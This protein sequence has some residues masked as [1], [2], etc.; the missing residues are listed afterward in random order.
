MPKISSLDP[1]NGPID[2]TDQLVVVDSSGA[3]TNRITRTAFLGPNIAS[4]DNKVL[5]TGDFVGTSDTQALI[6]KTLDYEANTFLNWPASSAGG[7]GLF[8]ESVDNLVGETPLNSTTV[9]CGGRSGGV[10]YWDTL[11]AKAD[12]DGATVIS[13][14]VPLG[15]ATA[16]N[17]LDGV[18]ETDAAGDGVWVRM[19]P[20]G[21][22][23]S[24]WFRTTADPT[25]DD[26]PQLQR[27][28]NAGAGQSIFIEGVYHRHVN[29]LDVVGN[30]TRIVLLPGCTLD[31][32]LT[33]V[34]GA[35]N[36]TT[37]SFMFN[38]LT[39]C[40]LIGYG[41]TIKATRIAPSYVNT[42]YVQGC[43]D[44]TIEGVT[45][46]GSGKDGIYLGFGNEGWPTNHHTVIRNCRIN[47]CQRQGISLIA[48]RDTLI[49]GCIIHDISGVSPSAAIDIEGNA[50]DIVYNTT[51]TNCHVYNCLDQGAFLVT[52][53]WNTIISN[54][55][56]YKC[57]GGLNIDSG[58][59]VTTHH[60]ITAVDD[61]NDTFTVAD[62]AAI[63]LI[64]HKEIRL[65]ILNGGVL[66][67]GI[68]SSSAR[69]RARNVTAT[70]FQIATDVVWP[71]VN[72][73][74]QGTWN[75]GDLRVGV[76]DLKQLGNTY[77][78]DCRIYDCNTAIYSENSGNFT[79][80]NIEIHND[81]IDGTEST[82]VAGGVACVNVDNV[83][84]DGIRITNR[85]VD[86][87]GN[88]GIY[89]VGLNPR[90]TNCYLEG[91]A[92]D[93]LELVGCRN[94]YVDGITLVDCGFEST[95]A[96]YLRNIN[97]GQVKNISIRNPTT[98]VRYGFLV[99]SG[100]S[101]V[102][103]VSIDDINTDGA[104]TAPASLEKDSCLRSAAQDPSTTFGAV[105]LNSGRAVR[106]AYA[107]SNL[108]AATI[109]AGA[110]GAFTVASVFGARV[111]DEVSLRWA[112]PIGHLQ[113]R[114]E[115]SADNVVT[116]Y[117]SN[118]TAVDIVS[119]DV[120]V[121][122]MAERAVR[123]SVDDGPV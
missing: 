40:S 3:T 63:G 115:V 72:L 31:S 104:A 20:Q 94:I 57:L 120:D 11:R 39:G 21:V 30:Y 49:E 47:F 79:A 95:I 98:S 116:V 13:P 22:W 100:I 119:F 1:L 38:N 42:V 48:A 62:T 17:Y 45:V 15:A 18:G 4:L 34:V 60:T 110:T 10:F 75:P 27:L 97:G 64:E 107:D 101:N 54:C 69:Y 33:P 111:G 52:L 59:S 85:P 74:S 108:T 77:I 83:I 106:G 6:N 36:G 73:T 118:P 51:I 50:G 96:M 80:R 71:N 58:G 117:Y 81:E 24:E 99:D 53:G 12:H 68:T 92:E 78:T 82:Q 7:G 35:V 90:V 26:Q 37:R 87:N 114:G 25:T 23:R 46:T 105:T 14:T 67:G 88:R 19:R 93:G 2:P 109:V 84:L 91:I 32:T 29:Q 9:V 102:R 56:V 65:Q 123:R 76:N 66:P 5:P 8:F 121:L 55:Q 86:L 28:L 113:T 70:T 89:L 16:A 41:A 112:G 61:I 43:I 103:N 44:T 122:V